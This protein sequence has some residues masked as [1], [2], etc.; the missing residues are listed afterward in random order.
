MISD[1]VGLFGR[2]QEN[3]PGE[4]GALIGAAPA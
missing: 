2:C 3:S 4:F 1:E